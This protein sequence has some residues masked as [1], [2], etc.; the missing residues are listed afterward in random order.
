M[1]YTLSLLIGITILHHPFLSLGNPI[2]QLGTG[3]GNKVEN[4]TIEHGASF[5]ANVGNS[6][7]SNTFLGAR[8]KTSSV[9]TKSSGNS[10]SDIQA[11]DSATITNQIGN[12]INNG[13]VSLRGSADG[14][15]P[16][17][18]QDF[19][20]A[21]GEVHLTGENSSVKNYLG[22]SFDNRQNITENIVNDPNYYNETFL[23]HIKH[24]DIEHN[25]YYQHAPSNAHGE[26]PS[27]DRYSSAIGVL[28]QFTRMLS[29][30]LNDKVDSVTIDFKKEDDCDKN[31]PSKPTY[32]SRRSS[33]Q[34]RSASRGKPDVISKPSDSLHK[35]TYKIPISSA[36][37][38][39]KSQISLIFT[40]LILLWI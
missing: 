25:Y 13:D 33:S 6:E 21:L 1:K 5:T 39:Q 20:G 10:V 15:N 29:Y 30:V 40:G 19:D 8:T 18:S 37:K 11:G 36:D 2:P 24:G 28:E 26:V 4:V 27:L 7:D 17:I 9:A 14:S 22:G 31:R 12:T 38:I 34:Y 16:A 35:N 23:Q 32:G 3:T